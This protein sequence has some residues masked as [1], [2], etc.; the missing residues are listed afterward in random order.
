[1]L[2]QSGETVIHCSSSL[3]RRCNTIMP[4]NPGITKLRE[5]IMT[6]Y[7]IS[8]SSSSLEGIA[9]LTQSLGT[10]GV[11]EVTMPMAGNNPPPLPASGATFDSGNTDMR[12]LE[13]GPPPLPDM[14]FNDYGNADMRHI[15]GGPPPLPGM[16]S[17]SSE[18][19]MPA[20]IDRPPPLPDTAATDAVITLP[21]DAPPPIPAETV[22]SVRKAAPK[23]RQ[24][25]KTTSKK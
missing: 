8:L 18:S 1:M 10:S 24:R 16:A 21:G 22:K 23:G 15:E 19:F 25:K 9:S 20:S 4:S 5:S 13:D 14:A 17:N 12:P 6:F 11:N 7:K 2:Q 3:T